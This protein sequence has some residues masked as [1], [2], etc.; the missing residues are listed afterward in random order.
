MKAVNR[1]QYNMSHII[2]H[3]YKALNLFFM[4]IYILWA[5]LEDKWNHRGMKEVAF[6]L[7]AYVE[8]PDY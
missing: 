7:S 8:H 5:T 1:Y 2:I 3:H 4:T 6:Q